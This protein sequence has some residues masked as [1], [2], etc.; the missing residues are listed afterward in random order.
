[1]KTPQQSVREFVQLKQSLGYK[2]TSDASVL[3]EF[4]RFMAREHQKRITTAIALRFASL[5]PASQAASQAARY[6]AVRLFAIY[7]QLH[8]EPR[9]ESL[10][11]KQLP[12]GRQRARPCLNSEAEILRLLESAR[13]Y[14]TVRARPPAVY[15]F[16]FGLLVVTGMRV[17]EA[18]GLEDRDI[19]WENAVLTV[20]AAK[21][22]RDRLVPLH[23]STMQQL[24]SY[25]EARDRALAKAGRRS[26]RLFLT[27]RGTALSYPGVYF[28]YLRVRQAAGL[29][30]PVGPRIHDLRHRFAVESLLRWYRLDEP[31][32]ERLPVLATYLGHESMVGTYWYL[33]CTPALMATAAARLEQRWEGGHR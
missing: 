28:V 29:N 31:I 21:F 25:Q 15:Y 7:D 11:A 8:R 3:V 16:L 23:A 4:G 27:S 17:R 32:E 14:R 18:L 30:R 26:P 24:R 10:P 5:R 19:D 13:R 12:S 22:G 6:N 9:N 2:F 33:S 20:R 1:M